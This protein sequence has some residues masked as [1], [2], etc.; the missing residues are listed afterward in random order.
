MPGSTMTRLAVGTPY[1]DLGSATNAGMVQ[2]FDFNNV[3]ADSSRTQ[4]STGAAGDAHDNSRYGSP[5]VA[6]EGAPERVWLVGNPFH[7]T[8]AVHVVNVTGGFSSRA[9][10]PGSGGVPGGASRFG[11]SF[12]GHDDLG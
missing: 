9:W 1:E 3:A 4:N 2:L 5:V 7:A 8:G 6:L 12:G 11:W 10:L